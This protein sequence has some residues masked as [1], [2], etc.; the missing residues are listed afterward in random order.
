MF[1]TGVFFVALCL[2]MFGG[3]L[4]AAQ[5]TG[6]AQGYQAQ[7]QSLDEETQ[8]QIQALEQQILAT[9]GPEREG[10]ELKIAEVKRQ[11][12]IQRLEILL[13]QAQ[14]EGDE[15]RVA[16]IRSALDHWLNP[17]EPQNLPEISGAKSG[18][19]SPSEKPRTI[20]K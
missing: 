5:E 15:A 20:S 13:E 14:T 12:E 10:L 6:G 4:W 19:Q 7:L 16:E 9:D 17:P 8:A 2:V 3:S 18:A 11:C 1:R